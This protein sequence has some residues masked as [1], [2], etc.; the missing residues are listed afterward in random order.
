MS[1]HA[2][3]VVRGVLGLADSGINGDLTDRSVPGQADPFH[4]DIIIRE[5]TELPYGGEWKGK[6]GLR[7]LMTKI[8]SVAT[9]TPIDVEVF[10]LGEDRVITR[11]IAKI[12]REGTDRELLIP[13]VEIYHME[14]GKIREIDVYYKD[15]KAMVDFFG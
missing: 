9:L 3:S 13:M 1:S 12:S 5:A 14:D 7:A 15:T 4:D 11:Q 2:A 6:E 10:D 8:D